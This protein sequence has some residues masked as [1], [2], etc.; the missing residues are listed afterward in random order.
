M[1]GP[2]LMNLGE[3]LVPPQVLQMGGAQERLTGLERKEQMAWKPK[4]CWLYC[5]MNR[6]LPG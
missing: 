3:T 2:G 5:W 4:G 6:S 1:P